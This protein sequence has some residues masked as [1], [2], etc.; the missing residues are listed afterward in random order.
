MNCKGRAYFD[1]KQRHKQRTALGAVDFT[2]LVETGGITPAS[3]TS[4]DDFE[5]QNA[6]ILRYNIMLLLRHFIG[7][8]TF[9]P[10][11]YALFNLVGTSR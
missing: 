3:F 11:L 1:H 9:D 7:N 2:R 8:H 6:T 5:C 4:I 10:K